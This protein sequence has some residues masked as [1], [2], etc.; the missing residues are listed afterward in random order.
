[1][2]EKNCS[3][4]ASAD[5]VI[6]L[7]KD[8]VG[9]IYRCRSCGLF[10]RD[11]SNQPKFEDPTVAIWG[12]KRYNIQRVE[13]EELQLNDYRKILPVLS[14]L[15]SEKRT[16]L[17][18]GCGTGNFLKLL[19]NDGWDKV[20][21]LEPSHTYSEIACQEVPAATVI[22]TFLKDAKFTDGFFDAI[23]MLHVIEHIEDPAAE[24]K[25]I[26]RVLKPTGILVIETPRF[27]TIWFKLLRGRERSIIPEHI[28]L[29]TTESLKKLLV[30]SGFEICRIDYVGRTL[31]CDRLLL[32]IA[33]VAGTEKTRRW[34]ANLSDK[35]KLNKFVFY[36]NLRD[37]MRVYARK[38]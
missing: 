30:N 31:S 1:M 3:I 7:K 33:R 8:N 23:I 10:Y 21:G 29:F 32:N 22:N 9:V 20:I 34:L 18:I 25:V 4:C 12:K 35:Y 26:H 5:V 14:C 16:V 37:M 11:A 15:S 2:L 24:L 38:L 28:F 6:H 19:Y 13:K 27:D 36:I 17:E